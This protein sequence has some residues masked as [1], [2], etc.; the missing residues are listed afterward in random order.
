M[1]FKKNHL[2]SILLINFFQKINSYLTNKKGNRLPKRQ[3]N[4]I[5]KEKTKNW[6]F[7]LEDKIRNFRKKTKFE[8]NKKKIYGIKNQLLSTF[9][10]RIQR[11]GE[12]FLNFENL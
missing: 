5:D 7:I 10:M 2:Y 4:D 11:K 9:F 6:M 1:N 3:E 8:S 12:I